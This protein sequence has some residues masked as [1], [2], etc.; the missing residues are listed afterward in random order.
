MGSTHRAAFSKKVSRRSLYR[1]GRAVSETS[2]GED[3]DPVLFMS[4]PAGC[5]GPKRALLFWKT[6]GVHRFEMRFMVDDGGMCVMRFRAASLTV[7]R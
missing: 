6:P 3:H 1:H 4:S 5:V 2:E 7:L